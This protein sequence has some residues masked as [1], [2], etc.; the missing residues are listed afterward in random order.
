MDNFMFQKFMKA[1]KDDEEKEEGVV[2][3]EKADISTLNDAGV[4]LLEDETLYEDTKEEK[5]EDEEGYVARKN[6]E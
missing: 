4:E 6:H 1:K 2:P 3:E 5:S